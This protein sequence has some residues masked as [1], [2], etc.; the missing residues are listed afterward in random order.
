[1]NFTFLKEIYKLNAVIIC[2]VRLIS[3]TLFPRDCA[4]LDRCLCLIGK[5]I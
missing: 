2:K 5:V 4:D 1:M 3:D